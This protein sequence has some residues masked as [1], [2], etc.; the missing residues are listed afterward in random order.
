MFKETPATTFIAAARVATLANSVTF[1][2]SGSR[3][4]EYMT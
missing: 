2:Y 1:D 4:N 3:E